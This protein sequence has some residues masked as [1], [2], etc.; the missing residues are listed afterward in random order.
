MRRLIQRLL[1]FAVATAAATTTIQA[2]PGHDHKVMGAIMLIDGRHVTMKTTDGKELTFEVTTTT[3][4][5]RAKKA[6]DFADL[7]PGMR[8]VCN[9]GDGDEPLHAKEVEYGTTARAPR[10]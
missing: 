3:K 1:L 7:K 2:H 9:V 5:V 8:I 10:P 4:L 6:G